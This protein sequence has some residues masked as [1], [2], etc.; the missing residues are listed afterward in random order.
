MRAEYD[1]RPGGRYQSP[2]NQAMREIGASDIAVDGEVLE[3]DPRADGYRA[4]D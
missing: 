1:L 2:T 3:V 4:G